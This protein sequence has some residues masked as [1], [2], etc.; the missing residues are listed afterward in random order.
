M[1]ESLCLQ[2]ATPAPELQQASTTTRF[3]EKPRLGQAS[4]W[5]IPLPLLSYRIFSVVLFQ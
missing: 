3:G 1:C 4:P 2:N 5:A